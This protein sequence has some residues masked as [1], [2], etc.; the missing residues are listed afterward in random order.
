MTDTNTKE[1]VKIE[2]LTRLQKLDICVAYLASGNS[3]YDLCIQL[4]ETLGGTDIRS[5]AVEEY[6]D[7]L[8]EDMEK[9]RMSEPGDFE[10]STEEEVNCLLK[11][12]KSHDY[13]YNTICWG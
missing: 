5:G 11:L 7:D 13:E 10:T 8:I 1:L 4:I 6:F 12:A 9:A 3:V 2:D